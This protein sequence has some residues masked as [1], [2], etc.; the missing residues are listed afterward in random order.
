M[1]LSGS[2][3]QLRIEVA[4]WRRRYKRLFDCGD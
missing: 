2:S 1:R 3:T 4:Y